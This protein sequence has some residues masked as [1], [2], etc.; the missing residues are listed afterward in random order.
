M[1][2]A[3]EPA[4]QRDRWVSCGLSVAFHLAALFLGGWTLSQ[5]ARYGVEQGL[6]GLEVYLVA[7]P[8][9]DPAKERGES[10]LPAVQGDGS[11]PVPGRDAA[12]LY[13]A[14]GGE[15]AAKPAALKNPA[16]PY[17]P[18]ARRLG[19]EGQVTLRIA[20][21]TAGLP[22]HVE[23]QRSSG[24]P[25]LDESALKAVCCWKFIPAR[26]AGVARAS[27][28]MLQVHFVLKEKQE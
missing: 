24:F 15:S 16:P 28:A 19:Q 25:L 1:P 2:R 14:G 22:T 10:G 13:S 7:A 11:S 21:D 20:I 3:A 9:G 5:S 23:V 26:T 4:A 12:T 8:R 27:V 18:L 6:G 17:P